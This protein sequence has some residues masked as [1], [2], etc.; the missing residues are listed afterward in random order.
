[1]ANRIDYND[2][3]AKLLDKRPRWTLIEDDVSLCS[4]VSREL[5]VELTVGQAGKLRKLYEPMEEEAA[6]KEEK[7]SCVIVLDCKEADPFNPVH[8]KAYRD[9]PRGRKLAEETFREWVE[10]AT[11]DD[12]LSDSEIKSIVDSGL[13]EVGE[14]FIALV[15]TTL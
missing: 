12:K 10:E 14:G 13:F 1:M 11:G 8:V 2:L 9:T 15:N 7:V 6:E 3:A 4:Y 5:G